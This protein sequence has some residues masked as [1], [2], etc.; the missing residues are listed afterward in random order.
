MGKWQLDGKSKSKWKA[1]AAGKLYIVYT[2]H[3]THHDDRIEIE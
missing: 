3:R 1:I 2:Q